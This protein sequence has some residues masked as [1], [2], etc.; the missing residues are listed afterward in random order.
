MGFSIQVFRFNAKDDRLEL[1]LEPH[2]HFPVEPGIEA[3][4]LKAELLS[5]SQA[6]GATPNVKDASGSS[7]PSYLINRQQSS[8]TAFSGKGHSMIAGNENIRMPHDLS[9]VHH[10]HKAMK[11]QD[12]AQS[13][14]HPDSIDEEYEEGGT[15]KTDTTDHTGTVDTL[16]TRKGPGYSVINPEL[17]NAVSAT[18]QLINNLTSNIQSLV[19]ETSTSDCDMQEVNTSIKLNIIHV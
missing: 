3:K 10:R 19:D 12:F 9:P 14:G 1:C 15:L 13:T 8:H 6:T 18:A 11:F 2:G 4:V 7:T 17:T 16:Y 5:H